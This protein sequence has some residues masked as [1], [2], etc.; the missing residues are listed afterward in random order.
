MRETDLPSPNVGA[1]GFHLRRVAS[2]AISQI[3]V[4]A[5]SYTGGKHPD[6]S[7]LRAFFSAC[8]DA[9]IPLDATPD[10]ENA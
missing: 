2:Q 5:P 4:S 7:S 8:A 10:D 9:L 3:E 6:A 1:R